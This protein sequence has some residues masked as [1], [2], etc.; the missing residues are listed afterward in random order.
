MKRWLILA[1]FMPLSAVAQQAVQLSWTGVASGTTVR[2]YRAPTCGE[3]FLLIAQNIPAAGPYNGIIPSAPGTSV[4]FQVTAVLNNLESPPSNCIVLTI[5]T[6]V[7]P[8]APPAATN[9]TGTI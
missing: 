8:T 1:A 7:V 5:P 6:P 2:V 3:S 4:A 9:L